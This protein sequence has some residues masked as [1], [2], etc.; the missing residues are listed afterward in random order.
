MAREAEDAEG[1]DEV[2]DEG[3][4]KEDVG[5]DQVRREGKGEA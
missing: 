1:E 4:A 2:E 3:E 5:G